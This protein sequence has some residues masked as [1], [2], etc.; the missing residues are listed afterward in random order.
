M[1]E[2]GVPVP[3]AQNTDSW[4][5]QELIEAAKKDPEVFGIL[6]A[7]YEKPL[8]RYLMRLTGWGEEEIVDILQESFIKAYRALNDYDRDLK[9]SSWIYRITHNQAIDTIR[10]ERVRPIF[11]ALPLEEATKIFSSEGDI[12]KTL[13]IQEDSARVQKAIANLPL[14]YREVLI[15]RFLEDR[16]YEEIMD[17]LKKPKGSV[18]TLIR[19]G[20][21][22]L[23]KKLE[24]IE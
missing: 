12:G 21:A 18:A 20:R 15:L 2:L 11:S 5:D 23:L 6:M 10:K 4:S 19:R 9:F 3:V 24:S 22:L 17:I 14:Q 7:R 8:Q 1:K 16:S 13:E